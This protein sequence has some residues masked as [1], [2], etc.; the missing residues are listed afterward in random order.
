M[1][2]EKTSKKE[3]AEKMMQKISWDNWRFSEEEIVEK[4]EELGR[5]LT[6]EEKYYPTNDVLNNMLEFLLENV[7]DLDSEHAFTIEL[8]QT[9]L[10]LVDV[11]K[12][13][14]NLK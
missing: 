8:M 10:E 14:K 13:I 5:E 4:E 12:V 2:E 1:A 11:D 9:V 3:I 6:D 7:E